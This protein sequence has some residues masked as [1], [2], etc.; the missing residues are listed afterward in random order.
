MMRKGQPHHG[1]HSP[2]HGQIGVSCLFWDTVGESCWHS[3]RHLFAQLFWCTTGS[4]RRLH[5]TSTRTCS[6]RGNLLRSRGFGGTQYCRLEQAMDDTQFASARRE[7]AVDSHPFLLFHSPD[8]ASVRL[9]VE[10]RTVF[11]GKST[12]LPGMETFVLYTS[13]KY[14]FVG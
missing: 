8:L 9:A 4:Q 13:W 10:R 3:V 2:F 14:P 5:P 12:E 1:S 11:F 6:S 7:Q